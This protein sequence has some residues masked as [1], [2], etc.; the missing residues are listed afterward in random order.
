[1]I[2]ISWWLARRDAGKPSRRFARIAI[3][4]LT[5]AI[6]AATAHLGGIVSGVNV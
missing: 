6:V 3:E 5:V 4:G 1:M 2:W